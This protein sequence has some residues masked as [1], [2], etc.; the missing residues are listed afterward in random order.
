M[1][2]LMELPKSHNQKYRLSGGV[3]LVDELEYTSTKKKNLLKLKE[4]ARAYA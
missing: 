1:D 2:E 3:V 4:M